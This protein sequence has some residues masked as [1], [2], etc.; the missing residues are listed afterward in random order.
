MF[1]VTNSFAQRGRVKSITPFECQEKFIEIIEENRNLPE[2]RRHI[3]SKQKCVLFLRTE[4]DKKSFF[5]INYTKDCGIYIDDLCKELVSPARQTDIS[6]NIYGT[7]SVKVKNYIAGLMGYGISQTPKLFEKEEI[8]TD[9]VIMSE[10]LAK[11]SQISKADCESNKKLPL[12]VKR[13]YWDSVRKDIPEYD[14]RRC[15]IECDDLANF[16]KKDNAC[17]CKEPFITGERGCQCPKD[18]VLT[19]DGRSCEKCKV[20]EVIVDGKCVEKRC[21]ERAGL[22]L[23]EFGECECKDTNKAY[24]S[25]T[26]RCEDMLNA[27]TGTVSLSPIPAPKPEEE[28]NEVDAT[29]CEDCGAYWDGIEC[30][31]LARHH[32][33]GEP[34]ANYLKIKFEDGGFVCADT[35]GRDY[36]E[37]VKINNKSAN[38]IS[39]AFSYEYWLPLLSVWQKKGN[40]YSWTPTR[41]DVEFTNISNIN[42]KSGSN[43][44]TLPDTYDKCHSRDFR[45]ENSLE[46]PKDI[47]S[48]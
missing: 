40:D 35:V 28:K 22:V 48:R 37:I 7:N 9:V 8:N 34:T 45:R 6:N 15:L 21:N 5:N 36:C 27:E 25:K 38:E 20:T 32:G 14:K 11:Q 12:G 13:M 23:N 16:M 39:E 10:G 18:M 31:W 43:Y 46:E 1:V 26:G 24:D 44:I 30:F 41:D 19:S 42:E 29:K 17:V 2:F 3:D 33:A 47:R 4:L